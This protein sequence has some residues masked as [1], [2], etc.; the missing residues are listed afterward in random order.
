MVAGTGWTL[1]NGDK[2]VSYQWCYQC[3]RCRYFET[4]EMKSQAFLWY[5]VWGE[6]VFL[7]IYSSKY[8]ISQLCW[9]SIAAH[10]PYTHINTQTHS[11]F[12]HFS[13]YLSI[14]CATEQSHIS[15]PCQE[16]WRGQRCSHV[17]T[18]SH[19]CLP[20]LC[21]SQ[22]ATCCLIT[23]KNHS[24]LPPLTLMMSKKIK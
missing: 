6:Q 23:H 16:D 11:D 9:V 1:K 3:C 15:A 10:S 12:W 18:H 2:Y 17:V 4:M 21:L 13:W 5:F 20:L 24:D 22:P 8:N 19:H 14:T 7:S